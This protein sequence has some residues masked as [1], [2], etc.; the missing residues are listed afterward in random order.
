ME[1]KMAY[2]PNGHYYNAALHDSC[3]ECAKSAGKTE[4]IGGAGGFSKTEKVG[5]GYS[6]GFSETVAVDSLRDADVEPFQPTMIGT[7]SVEGRPRSP[8]S[9]GWS[10]SRASPAAWT[11]A[12]TRATTTSAAR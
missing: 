3:P 12:C 1:I 4:A 9:A 7:E 10:A 6:G 11:T 5:G 2:C 8:L